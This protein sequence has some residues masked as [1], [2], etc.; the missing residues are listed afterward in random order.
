M[1]PNDNRRPGWQA[2]HGGKYDSSGDGNVVQLFPHRK[3]DWFA[4]LTVSSPRAQPASS[5]R[6]CCGSLPSTH[7]GRA[8]PFD[9]LL[10]NRERGDRV[11]LLPVRA[12][13]LKTVII[14]AYFA[15]KL[16]AADVEGLFE[17]YGLEA[18]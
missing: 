3:T 6:S 12:P 11:I 18:D 13:D 14:D 1:P 8:M 16:S 15:G 5:P 17:Q 4:D 7:W 2:R 10:P 9:V